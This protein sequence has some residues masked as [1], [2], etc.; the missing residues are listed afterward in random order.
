M[1]EPRGE[2]LCLLMTAD[3]VGGVWDYSLELAAGLARFGVRTVLATMGRLPTPGQRQAASAVPG[4]LLQESAFRLEWMPDHGSDPFLAG[5][6]LLSL[7]ERF[8]PD[9]VHLNGYVHG[10]L[11]WRAPSLVVAHSCVLSW[12]QAV[13]GE[14]APPEWDGYA[15]RVAAGLEGARAVVTPTRALLETM[16][17]LYGPL[18]HARTIWNG[19]DPLRYRPEV[20]GSFVFSAGRLWDEAKNVAALE[21]VGHELEW[22]VIAAGDWRHPDGRCRRP[23]RME[24]LGV[25]PGAEMASWLA[26]API[27]AL[28]ARYEPF[29][30]SVL[31]AALSGCALV[32]G[33]I[34]TLRELWDGAAVFVPPDD[35]ERLLSALQGLIANRVRLAEL[36]LAARRRG[37][38]YT[39]ERM[40][41]AYHHLYAELLNRPATLAPPVPRPEV[42]PGAAIE[43]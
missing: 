12:W 29:G 6:W 14:A 21:T 20:K 25:L 34:P 36:S 5:Q 38:T 19:R 39:A 4:L 37:M 13:K 24:T 33:D 40:A 28:P 8:R 2:G 10:S 31:E 17:G 16:R 30:L 18:P 9:I 27:Y 1:P 3:T 22:P 43:T 15:R 23:E 32:L 42:R 11:P 35:P 41:R 7:E 26:R